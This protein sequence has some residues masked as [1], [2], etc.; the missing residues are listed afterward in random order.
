MSTGCQKATNTDRQEERQA[1]RQNDR[2]GGAAK[3]PALVL[4]KIQRVQDQ[5]QTAG[6]SRHITTEPKTEWEETILE[7]R[8]YICNYL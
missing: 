5:K 6:L 4:H 8:E 1:D 7:K 2:N 3:K